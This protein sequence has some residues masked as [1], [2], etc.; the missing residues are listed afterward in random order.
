MSSI[1]LIKIY[2]D[3]NYYSLTY[4]YFQSSFIFCLGSVLNTASHNTIGYDRIASQL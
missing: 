4:K 2:N 3:N 1:N